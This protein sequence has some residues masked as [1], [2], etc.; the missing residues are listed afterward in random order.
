MSTVTAPPR[1]AAWGL[2]RAA[3]P[4]QWTK[5]VLVAA[6]PLA[7]GRLL[8]PAVLVGTLVA[9][10]AFSLTASGV[11]LLNDV[12]DVEEDRRHPTKRNRPVAAGVLSPAVAVAAS[13]V[14]LGLGM[15][16]GWLRNP[17][18]GAVLTVYVVVQLG[19]VLWLKHEPVIDLVVVASG[20][21]LRAVA[22]GTASDLVL[23]QWF[24]LVA[25]FGSLFL[26]AGKR[27]SEIHNLGAE[28]GTRRSLASY[29]ESY[30]RFVWSM[31][32]AITIVSYSLWAFQTNADHAGTPWAA[33]SIAPLVLALLRY[34]ADIDRG[35][36]A[37]PEDI[38]LRDRVL[39]TLGVAWA[40]LVALA[41]YT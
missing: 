22:G 19:Y 3:R 10:A 31:A 41:V 5:N 13:G 11:Y 34:A 9:F 36:A 25:S 23:S 26:V 32:A 38:V 4:R 40:A 6:A 37:A 17:G 18:L 28:A 21:L 7:A 29:S 35:T 27:Y 24:L 14:L 16:V 2:V 15:V 8:E 30:L 39:Q 1:S 33:V 12:L 20:F